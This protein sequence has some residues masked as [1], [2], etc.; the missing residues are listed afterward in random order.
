MLKSISLLVIQLDIK[1]GYFKLKTGQYTLIY[2]SY[3]ITGS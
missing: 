2:T 3:I 1:V